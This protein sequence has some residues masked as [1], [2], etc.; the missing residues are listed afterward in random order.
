MCLTSCCQGE[1]S[2]SKN[3]PLWC[4]GFQKKTCHVD[5][6]RWLWWHWQTGTCCILLLSILQVGIVIWRGRQNAPVPVPTVTTKAGGHRSW[7]CRTFQT[8][9][10]YFYFY[11]KYGSIFFQ[12]ESISQPFFQEVPARDARASP[13]P[14]EVLRFWFSRWRERLSEQNDVKE[15]VYK[16]FGSSK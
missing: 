5:S 7:P 14:T 10:H 9:T 2:E 1:G 13:V 8:H 6:W 4:A 11:C 3:E 15:I 16:V 12:S